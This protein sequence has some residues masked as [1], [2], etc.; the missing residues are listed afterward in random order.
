MTELIKKLSAAVDEQTKFL[1]P[2]AGKLLLLGS[3]DSVF[4]KALA[5]KAEI[6][7]IDFVFTYHLNPPLSW[8]CRRYRNRPAQSKTHC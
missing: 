3:R 2:H 7:G 8:C 1:A 5:K 6:L 4:L